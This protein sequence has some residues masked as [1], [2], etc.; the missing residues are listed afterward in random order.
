MPNP[1]VANEALMQTIEAH[2]MSGKPPMY[3]RKKESK[4]DISAWENR[5]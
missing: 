2:R 4:N 3:S 1:T 5:Y